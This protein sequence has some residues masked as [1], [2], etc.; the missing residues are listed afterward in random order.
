[1]PKVPENLKK[2]ILEEIEQIDYGR[3][4]IEIN[5]TSDKI[6]VVTERREQ[7]AKINR[8]HIAGRG[9]HKG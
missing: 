1:M 2:H 8:Q 7:F 9:L 6:Y 5:G 4:I 3:V